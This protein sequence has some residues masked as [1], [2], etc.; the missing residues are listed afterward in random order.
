MQSNL[1]FNLLIRL[2]FSP[3]FCLPTWTEIFYAALKLVCIF[4]VAF[5][6]TDTLYFLG[7]GKT[8]AYLVSIFDHLKKE[9]MAVERSTKLTDKNTCLEN[10]TDTVMG[11]NQSAGLEAE[12]SINSE[13][14]SSKVESPINSEAERSINLILDSDIDAGKSKPSFTHTLTCKLP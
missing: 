3:S 8:A 11:T 10:E 12:S 7:S 14:K 1:D 4:W 9:E 2:L 13:A 5:F 6:S